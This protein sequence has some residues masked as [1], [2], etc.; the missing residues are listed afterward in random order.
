MTRSD[1]KCSARETVQLFQQETP[2]F[3]S[4][5]LCLPN[6]SDLNPVDHRIWGLMQDCVFIVQDTC[7]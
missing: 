3:I 1:V 4:P 5:D 6:R 2:D 7:P